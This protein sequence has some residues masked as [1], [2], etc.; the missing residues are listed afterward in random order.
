[1]NRVRA[2][3]TTAAT[4][5]LAGCGMQEY[6]S[7]M[8]TTLSDKKEEQKLKAFTEDPAQGKV[9]GLNVYLRPPKPAAEESGLQLSQGPGMFDFGTSYTITPK[10]PAPKEGE[11][12]TALAPMKMHVLIRQKPK[13]AAPKKAD[14][15]AAPAD[16]AAPPPANRGDFR[17]DVRA[18][19]A[20]DFGGDV[21][22]KQPT[23]V[24]KGKTAFERFLF[25]AS[26]G[27]SSGN[28]IEAYL[29]NGDKG[30]LQV[31]LIFDYPPS[32]K[33][34]AVV[35]SGLDLC[36]KSFALGSKARGSSA[37]KPAKGGEPAA[38]PAF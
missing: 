20:A 17:S 4:L 11:T 27:A 35:T 32:I 31:A 23:K 12:A 28:T 5:I 15:A 14:P 18:I 10:A 24:S 3:L 36:L 22:E 34:N 38:G 37:A 9:K 6:E 33:S 21:A 1:M 30:D 13:K 26:S 7:R 25:T 16:P 8:A 19:L 2:M 29:A